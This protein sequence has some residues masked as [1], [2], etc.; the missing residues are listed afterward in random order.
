MK[1]KNKN[2]DK[3]K[4]HWIRAEQARK[5]YFEDYVQFELNLRKLLNVIE[6]KNIAKKSEIGKILTLKEVITALKTQN[7]K[8]GLNLNINKFRKHRKL[9]NWL[10]HMPKNKKAL[11]SQFVHMQYQ[12]KGVN[13]QLKKDIYDYI[14]QK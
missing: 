10:A 1:N 7:H 6:E 14:K 3:I 9:R 5:L 12:I 11:M 8:K 4:K 2:N 13:S